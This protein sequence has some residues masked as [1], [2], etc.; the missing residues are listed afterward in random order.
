MDQAFALAEVMVIFYMAR[1]LKVWS[2]LEAGEGQGLLNLELGI[3]VRGRRHAST[4]Q[5]PQYKSQD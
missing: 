4:S 2:N 3:R 1:S 5:T